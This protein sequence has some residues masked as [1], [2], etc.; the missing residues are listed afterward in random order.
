MARVLVVGGAGYIGAHTCKALSHGGFEPVTFDNLSTGHRNFVRWGHFVEGDIH[1]IAA[2]TQ[3]AREYGTVATIHFAASAYVGE[4]VVD[5]A[6]YYCNN[7]AGSLS[8]LRGLHEAG[9]RKVVFSS[10]CA[11]Y[12]QPE[13]TPIDETTRP[14][15]VNPY[16]RSKLMVEQI[17][18]DF[19]APYGFKFFALRYFNAAGADPDIEIGEL[20]A[21][22]THLIPRAMMALQG[23]IN[24]FQVFGSDYPTPDRT[25]IRDYVHVC[26]LAEAHV[27][28][29]RLL[30]QDHEGGTLNLGTGV[31]HSVN[32]VLTA[33]QETTGAR[34]PVVNG[35]RRLGD[36]ARL[37]ADP[38]R[39]C[40]V[41]GFHTRYSDIATI[42]QTA[43]EWHRR[44]HPH[45]RLEETRSRK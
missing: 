39:A 12:G 10:T 30:L 21:P 41:L 44:A 16:G 9:C 23:Y 18:S 6:K 13:K 26:D 2:I 8:L 22:E 7:I 27:G 20:R 34:L 31:G 33:I 32:D 43:W 25:A 40:K 14:E 37:I 19:R 29:V 28:A 42:V 38:S 15:P 36:P 35:S 17:L 11:V 1:D 24:D 4:S 5:P 3:T 45:R